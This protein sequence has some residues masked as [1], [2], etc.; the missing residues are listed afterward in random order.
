[1]SCDDC[2][3]R[4][5]RIRV[6]E[7]DLAL[8]ATDYDVLNEKAKQ[9]FR[10]EQAA[11]NK[12]NV[13]AAT[14]ERSNEIRGL[15]DHWRLVCNHERSKTPPGSDR[16]NAVR[17]MLEHFSI[18][19]VKQAINGAARF[20]YVVDARRREQGSKKQRFDDL[21]LICRDVRQVERF[22]ELALDEDGEPVDVQPH[23]PV[24]NTRLLD[25]A[26]EEAAEWRRKAED[27]FRALEITGD[28]LRVSDLLLER[29]LAE[30]AELR[31]A[32]PA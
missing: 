9:A 23:E 31:E 20:P 12:V 19:E 28:L 2:A 4:D 26:I 25:E 7:R 10:A 8:M 14:D 6:L 30:N 16:W 18:F 13:T 17:K 24:V 1:V 11:K 22:M 29:A 3:Y 21:T 32:V 15:C 27:R 5:E